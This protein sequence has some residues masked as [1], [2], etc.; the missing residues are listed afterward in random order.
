MDLTYSDEQRL[1]VES[2]RRFLESRCTPAVVRESEHTGHGFLAELWRDTAAQGWPG[3]ALPV[4]FGGGDG[5]ITDLTVLA[6]EL[7][8]FAFP[9]PLLTSFALGVLP[10]LWHGDA[11][12]HSRW[13]PGLTSGAT[14]ATLALAEPGA[15]DE[16]SDIVLRGTR[17][18]NGWQLHG[19]KILVPYAPNADVMLIAAALDGVGTAI[20]VLESKDTRAKYT[21]HDSISRDSLFAVDFDGVEVSQDALLVGPTE[22]RS[23]LE[24]GA[25][26]RRRSRPRVQHRSR[27]SGARS[28]GRVRTQP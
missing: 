5:S 16:W 13:M 3:I 25:R 21:R 4:E 15:R 28:V 8:R 9:S 11:A 22:V 2:A 12:Q 6:E 7:G 14:I 10:V 19:T 17:V 23:A 27:G 20:V 18:A 24:R 26:P 1:L